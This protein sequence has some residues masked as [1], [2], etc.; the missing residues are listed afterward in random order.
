MLAREPLVVVSSV[1]ADVSVDHSAKTFADG[2]ENLLVTARSHQF[3]G[4]VGVHARAVP[5]EFAQRLGMPFD[6]IPILLPNPLQQITGY[7][8]LVASPLGSLGEDL[9]LPLA[10]GHF[11][12]DTFNVQAGF[13]AGIEM[14]FHAGP[15]VGIFCSDRAVIGSL[16]GRISA[17]GKPGRVVVLCAPEKILLFEAEPEILVIVGYRGS[18]IRHMRRTVSTE[19]L[20]HD[21]VGVLA[22]RIRKNRDRLEKAI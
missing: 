6:G 11:S 18:G 3:V 13:E 10:G 8:D 9:K 16:R 20:R 21:E 7:P 14:L 5:V 15:T 1:D 4:K 17:R 22:A 19:N 12:I 2:H